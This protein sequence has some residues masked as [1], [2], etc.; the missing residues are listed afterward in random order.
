MKTSANI[1]GRR[2]AGLL[3]AAVLLAGCSGVRPYPNTLA[4][5]LRIR[6]ETDS[7]IFSRV[8]AEI[9]IFSVNAD[10]KTEYQGTVDLKGPS[11]EVGVPS[12][13]MSYLVFVFSRSSFL[14]SS[15]S[16][17]SHEALLRA[18]AGY[19]YDIR[20]SYRDD[21]YD[22]AIKEVHPRSK[23]REIEHRDISSCGS[24]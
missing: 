8:R 2:I 9:D 5:N 16:S 23:A 6:T 22:V 20:V 3:L 7:S 17:M 1:T 13:K 15:R 19:T 18:R 14:A 21:I 12:G 4:K 24:I 11:T 10:C